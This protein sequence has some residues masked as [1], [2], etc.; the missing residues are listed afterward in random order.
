MVSPAPQ[1]IDAA[2]VVVIGGGITGC[3]IAY[4]LAR[5]GRRDVL[6]LERHELAAATTSKSAGLVSLGGTS[7]AAIRLVKRTLAAVGELEEESGEPVDFRRVGTLRA[8]FGA[9]RVADL[10]TLEVALQGEGVPTETI[11]VRQA[12]ERC[13]WLDLAEAERVT[14][15]PAGG[16]VD[17]PRLAMAYARAARSRG[18]RVWR[19]VGVLGLHR[20]GDRIVGVETGRGAIRAGHVVDAAGAWSHQVARWA[21]RGL[22]MVPT[23]SHYWLTAPDGTGDPCQPSV[24]LL[25]HSAY[26]RPEVG[27]LLVGMQERRSMTFSPE[28]LPDEL[29]RLALFDAAADQDLLVD[30]IGPLRRFAPG[31]DQWRFAHH[32]AGL[33][34]YTPDGKPILGGFAGIEGFLV[35]SGCCGNGVAASGGVGAVIADL[36]DGRTPC[37]DIE[38]FRPDRFGAVDPTTRDF[39]ALCAA[40]RVGKTLGR[41]GS[42]PQADVHSAGTSSPGVSSTTSRGTHDSIADAM[43]PSL[44]RKA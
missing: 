13:P 2:E 21:G 36:I 18:V 23:R 9:D 10:L 43:G 26:F 32:I 34:T 33:S 41:R 6:V 14:L 7:A 39:Q 5:A 12:R 38:E 4:H 31:I 24:H 3:S 44:S 8:A 28:G 19:Q 35:A 16:Y 25:G 40:A 22:G 42:H 29:D 15:V 11:D 30:G 17:A 20:E 1:W 37:V 27:G